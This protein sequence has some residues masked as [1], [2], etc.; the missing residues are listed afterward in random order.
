MENNELKKDLIVG[1]MALSSNVIL[2]FNKRKIPRKIFTPLQGNLPFSVASKKPLQNSDYYAIVRPDQWKKSEKYPFGNIETLI[3]PVGDYQAELDCLKIK[4]NIKWKKW[5]NIDLKDYSDD[6]TPNR[7]DL[8]DLNT[9]S[10]DPEGCKD[11]DDCLHIKKLDN[12]LTEIGV[13]IADVSSYIPENSEID[14]EIRKRGQSVYLRCEQMNMLPEEMATNLFSLLENKKRRVF[15]VIFTI[16]DLKVQEV[17]FCKSFIIN[18]KAMS[19]KEASSLKSKDVKELFDIAYIFYSRSKRT[20]IEVYDIH[21]TI[22]VYMVMANSAVAEYLYKNV[23]DQTILR[24]HKNSDIE[25][26][27]LPTRLKELDNS[28]ELNETVKL[29]NVMKQEK[30]SYEIMP[31]NTYHEGLG[32]KFYTHF[33]S[34]IRRYIDIIIHRQLNALLQKEKIHEENDKEHA[35]A[36]C[37]D[38]NKYQHNIKNAERESGI[39]NIIYDLYKEGSIMKTHGFIIS[40]YNCILGVY[41]P[42]F[43][44]VL[45]CKPFHNK[46]KDLINYES[47]D[48]KLTIFDKIKNNY[49]KFELLDKVDIQVVISMKT[50]NLKNKI[51]IKILNEKYLNIMKE[52]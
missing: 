43:K 31:E 11:I 1:T 12:G 7:V 26:S 33:T 41:I 50:P 49:I 28:E 18:K 27:Y 16:K 30:A 37:I 46:I 40:I 34:P 22:E 47:D 45:S 23:P 13:H 14:K 5:K 8:T 52:Y 36:L 2:G 39:F 10:I 6:L 9:I 35:S 38:L 48:K 29:I 51:L 17:R 4:H 15:S 42:E 24:V 25:C 21:K 20:L 44:T 3:G 19:Y 32:E